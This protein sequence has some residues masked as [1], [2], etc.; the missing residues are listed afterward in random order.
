MELRQLEYLLAVARHGHFTRAAEELHVAQP[1]VSQQLRRLERD[2]GFELIDRTNRS[3]TAAGE[4]LATR[5]SRALS[6]LEAAR[7]ELEQLGGLERGTVRVG[8]IHWLAP[9]DLAAALSEFTS[10][11]PGI[12][13]TLREEDA[14]RMLDMLGDGQLDLVLHN[15]SAAT[16]RVDFEQRV[17]FTEELVVIA[18]ETAEMAGRRS[19]TLEEMA[20]RRI[21]AFRRGAAFRDITDQA[22]A[23]LG[24]SPRIALESSDL[25]TIRSLVAEGLGIALM[26]RSL[27]E[28]P[29]Q[30][31][32]QLAV[33]PADLTR[34]V[35]LTRRSDHAIAPAA[36]ALWDHLNQWLDEH[37]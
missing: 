16:E 2:V 13:I 35:A 20:N 11:H 25:V 14:T 18:A 29:G 21:V 32:A 36:G 24:L 4:I 5:A 23:V 26:P 8:A 1:A 28:M 12:D 15:I 9:F 6:E 31:V 19:I 17:M 30:P 33:E 27:A 37:R 7:A 10:R 34:S 3:L 22:F